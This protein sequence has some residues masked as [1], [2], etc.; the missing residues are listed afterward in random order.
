MVMRPALQ[1]GYIVARIDPRK[2]S[3]VHMRKAKGAIDR[4]NGVRKDIFPIRF[5]MNAD[6]SKEKINANTR[7]RTPMINPSMIT[8]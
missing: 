3:P 4:G 2:T 1:A 8:S 6:N 7:L 5:P